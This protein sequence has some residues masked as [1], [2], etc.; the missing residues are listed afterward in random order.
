M[1]DTIPI[2]EDTILAPIN[3]YGCRKFAVEHPLT[4]Y[5][6]SCDVRSVRLRYFNVGGCDPNGDVGESHDPE[7]H[8]VPRAILAALG[9]SGNSACSC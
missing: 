4:D 5:E 1:L 8:L 9:T 2:T 7:T 6:S 3:P